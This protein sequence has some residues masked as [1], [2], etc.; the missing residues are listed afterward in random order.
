MLFARISA[1]IAFIAAF[2]GA[3][4]LVEAEDRWPT[5]YTSPIY[6]Y[7]LDNSPIQVTLRPFNDAEPLHRAVLNIPRAYIVFANRYLPSRIPRLPPAIET[8]DIRVALTY[9]NGSALSLHGQEL[10]STMHTHFAEA[11]ESLRSQRYS[12][13]IVYLY[14]DPEW[15]SRIRRRTANM[16]IVGVFD[17]LEHVRW[18]QR[19]LYFGRAGDD[20]FIEVSCNVESESRAD[21]FCETQMRIGTELVAYVS[22]VDFRFHGGRLFANARARAFRDAMCRFLIPPCGARD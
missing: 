14:P 3:A 11:I 12:A 16:T 1:V 4:R 17:G 13:R 20:E 9:P 2:V 10:S 22:F 21:A 6:Y 7:S 5:V 19:D 8:D 15:E 18:L